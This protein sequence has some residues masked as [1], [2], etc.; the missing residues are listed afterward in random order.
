MIQ[1]F[2]HDSVFAIANAIKGK[3]VN[4]LKVIETSF[5]DELLIIKLSGGIEL[6]INFPWIDNWGIIKSE[7]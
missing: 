4:E 6:H 1:E 2:N 7:D 5:G 3:T